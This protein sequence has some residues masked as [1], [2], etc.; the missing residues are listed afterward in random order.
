MTREVPRAIE[1][2]ENSLQLRADSRVYGVF[3]LLGAEH[4]GLW[5]GSICEKR[6]V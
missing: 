4:D 3:L 2:W 1:D 6:G 5:W